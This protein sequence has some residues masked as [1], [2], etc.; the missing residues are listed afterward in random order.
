MVKNKPT[1]ITDLTTEIVNNSVLLSAWAD[2]SADMEFLELSVAILSD[3]DLLFSW[4]CNNVLNLKLAGVLSGNQDFK[5]KSG[6]LITV[7]ESYIFPVKAAA[8]KKN[9]KLL[10]DKQESLNLEKQDLLNQGFKQIDIEKKER[11]I[12]MNNFMNLFEKIENYTPKNLTHYFNNL[13]PLLIKRYKKDK[14]EFFNRKADDLYSDTNEKNEGSDFKSADLIN[15]IIEVNPFPILFTS[16]VVYNCFLNYQKHI[17]D[18][19]NDY[20]YLK[21]R[22][23]LQQL[24]HYQKDNDFM[25]IVF[26]QMNLISKKN[27]EDYLIIGKLNSLKRTSTAQRENNF[28]NIFGC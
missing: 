4:D 17:I 12:K 11:F 20:S 5:L 10:I 18:F 22:L 25:K 19:Y 2:N 9:I 15:E 27:Y 14:K 28:N 16:H 21:K 23:E 6:M 24:T 3:I 1:Y 26:E 7:D 8:Y 13:L